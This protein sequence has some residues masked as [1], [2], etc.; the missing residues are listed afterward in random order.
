[1]DTIRFVESASSETCFRRG[2]ETRDGP[3]L[4]NRVRP[5][6]LKKSGALAFN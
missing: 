4:K 6:F 5:L 1:L 3:M 2:D